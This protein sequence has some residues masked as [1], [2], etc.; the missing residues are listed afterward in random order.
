MAGGTLLATSDV[1]RIEAP[2]TVKAYLMC[3]FASFGGIFFG[4]DSVS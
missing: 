4:F 1:S 3:A 2:V